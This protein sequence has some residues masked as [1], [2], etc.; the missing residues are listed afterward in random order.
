MVA[1]T[2]YGDSVQ[3]VNS[4]L[5]TKLGGEDEEKFRFERINPS[6]RRNGFRRK[7]GSIDILKRLRF[8][9]YRTPREGLNEGRNVI[10]YGFFFFFCKDEWNKATKSRIRKNPPTR[11]PQKNDGGKKKTPKSCII[12][13]RCFNYVHVMQTTP[14]CVSYIF[15]IQIF[16]LCFFT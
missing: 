11:P 6:Q 14:L 4:Y 15:S 1:A 7:G 5:G 10:R 12:S 8:K 2:C 9:S 16:S 13:K 3:I